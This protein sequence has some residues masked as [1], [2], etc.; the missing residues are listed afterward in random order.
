MPIAQPPIAATVCPSP[1]PPPAQRP[2]APSHRRA[3]GMPVQ[4]AQFPPTVNF[5]DTDVFAK[6]KQDGVV[7][8][9]LASNEEFLRRVTLD[10]T[11]AI[12]TPATV[13]AFLNSAEIRSE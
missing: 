1:A 10:L 11:G 12:P 9:A 5:I 2:V 13:D 8:T 6:M 3:A 4:P 7:P